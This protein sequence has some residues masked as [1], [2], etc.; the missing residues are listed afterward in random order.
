MKKYYLDIK[1]IKGID[2][3]LELNFPINE[4]AICRKCAILCNKRTEKPN[5]ITIEI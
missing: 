2:K 5:V 3:F 4:Y 1:N